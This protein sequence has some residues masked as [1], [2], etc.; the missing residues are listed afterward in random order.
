[1]IAAWL[2]H[3]YTASGFVLAFLAT[4]ATIAH[5]YRRAFLW[6][7]LQV[8]IDATDGWLARA[9][10]V[11]E[12]LPWFSGSK[13]DDLVDYLTY[14]FVPAL[15]VWHGML[16]P[17][18]LAT[19][20]ACVLL[21]SSGFGFSRLD[22]KTTDH[23]FTGFPSYWNVVVLYLVE[24]GWQP[25]TNAAVLIGLSVLVF[26][27][28][29]FVYPSRTPILPVLTNGL[30]AIWSASILAILWWQPDGRQALMAWTLLYPAYYV[31]L[32]L[33]LELCRFRARAPVVKRRPA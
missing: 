2:V 9:A 23:F 4:E 27:P 1:V 12:H 30:G 20:V 16:V 29:R 15:M 33:W 26:V 21:V 11:T 8:V 24:L 6:L 14:V 19:L 32:S 7:W 25:R 3:L 31:T 5:D 18:P 28:M 22:A 10:N 13:L 17:A